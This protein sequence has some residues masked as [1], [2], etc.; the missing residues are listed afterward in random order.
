MKR[1]LV[2]LLVLAMFSTASATD[3][4]IADGIICNCLIVR[5][6][7]EGV[8]GN[9]SI[10]DNGHITVDSITTAYLSQPLALTQASITVTGFADIGTTLAVA[11]ISTL[12]GAVECV[13]TLLIGGATTS[14]GSLDQTIE[15]IVA[16]GENGIYTYV[17]HIT[18]ALTGNLIAIKGN[19]CVNTIDSPAGNVIGGHFQAG[20]MDV[21]TDLAIVRGVYTELVNK[22]PVGATTWTYAKAYEA[23]M[24]LDQG[25]SG[26]VNTITNAYMFYGVYN[27]PTVDTYAT[28][29]NGYG[30]FIRNEA[31]GGTGQML[32]AAFYAD[33][34]S[35]SGGIFGWDY[36]LDFGSM[37]SAG[38]GTA[39]IRGCNAETIDNITDGVWNF[40][41]ADMRAQ[42]YNFASAAAVG[43]TADAITIDFT[44]DFPTLEAGIR[45]SFIAEGLNTGATTLNID[46]VGAVN[47]FENTD[48][49]ACEGGEIVDG[50]AV[51]LMHDGTQWQIISNQ[52]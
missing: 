18:N 29:T 36:G 9:W 24:D 10:N 5:N 31:V 2:M 34:A 14:A 7:M 28:V 41:D 20:N 27:L 21:G 13:T 30:V 22:I 39:D 3:Y 11:G 51:E 37:G 47:V 33:D 8:F 25:T 35:M 15:T 23:N 46:G 49:S 52:P 40:A 32:D 44:P 16:G 19:A 43:G 4:D 17:S 50:M 26:N 1:L 42:G 45:V 12:T 48:V 38:F 6:V